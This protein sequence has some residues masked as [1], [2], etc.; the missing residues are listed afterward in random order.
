MQQLPEPGDD[1]QRVVDPDAEAD[2]RHEDLRDR[3]EVGQPRGEEEDQ[4]RAE[5]CDDREEQRDHRRHERAEQNEQDHE[6][7]QQADQVA[8][9]LGRRGVSRPRR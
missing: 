5:D 3:V 2:H 8:D 6:R 7:G 1:E 4:E 9:P